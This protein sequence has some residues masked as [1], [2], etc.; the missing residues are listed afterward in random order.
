[1]FMLMVTVMRNMTCLSMSLSVN[2]EDI[3]KA[4]SS[5]LKISSRKLGL[6]TMNVRKNQL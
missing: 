6:V 5:I 2:Y 3:S 1:M 4:T